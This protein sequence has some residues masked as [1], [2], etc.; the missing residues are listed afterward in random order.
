MKGQSFKKKYTAP[1]LANYCPEIDNAPEHD[2]IKSSNYQ[3]LIGNLR[4]IVEL[5]RLKI[6]YEVSIDIHSCRIG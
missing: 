1:I 3:S 6:C 5:G 4:W 2:D